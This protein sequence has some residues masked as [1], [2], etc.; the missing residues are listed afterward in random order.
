VGKSLNA[1]AN[2]CVSVVLAEC[3]ISDAEHA[4]AIHNRAIV[5][6]FPSSFLGLMIADPCALNARRG[7]RSDTFFK[8]LAGANVIDELIDYCL[9]GRSMTVPVA[10]VTNHDDRAAL[11]CA[12]TAL[13]V[14][15]EDY[16]AVGDDD[17]WIILPPARFIRKWAWDALHANAAEIGF[18]L[19]PPKQSR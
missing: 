18:G 19:Y 17:G 9:P 16:T 7:D 13:C 6:A 5:E 12:L 15:T 14:L 11:V 1:H 3:K 8:H 2:A 10:T 4:V